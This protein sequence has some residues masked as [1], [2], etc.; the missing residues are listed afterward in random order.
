MCISKTAN[1][2]LLYIATEFDE[3]YINAEICH[4]MHD[5]RH[6]CK[7][8]TYSPAWRSLNIMKMY[9]ILHVVNNTLCISAYAGVLNLQNFELYA[10]AS[11]H[12]CV[13]IPDYIINYFHIKWNPL[14]SV[15]LYKLCHTELMLLMHM[16][17]NVSAS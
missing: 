12:V 5:R 15:K 6:V 8:K 17:S 2:M 13:P 4:G 1:N 11:I 3:T 10:H 9:A 14:W 7:V 16:T